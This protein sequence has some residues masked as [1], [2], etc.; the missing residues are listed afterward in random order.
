[1]SEPE[2]AKRGR[3]K[4]STNPPGWT[5]P[6]RLP[7]PVTVGQVEAFAQHYCVHGHAKN[8]AIE[9]GLPGIRGAQLLRKPEV[10]KRI[11]QL[12]AE[13]FAHVGVTAETVK[14][15]LARVAFASARDLFDEDGALIA[16]QDLPDD[17]AATIAGID[18][19]VRKEAGPVHGGPPT[20]SLIHI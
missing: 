13:Q 12:N 2:P 6:T 11:Q 19:E 5:P 9:A 16:P 4:G 3:P 1:M 8:A 18:V 20:L 17:V 10:V 14:G 15:E 7:P